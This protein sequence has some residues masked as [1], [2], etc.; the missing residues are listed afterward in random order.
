MSQYS[1]DVYMTC[2]KSNSSIPCYT[3]LDTLTTRLTDIGNVFILPIV[4]FYSF[5]LNLLCIIVFTRKKM[6]GEVNELFFLVSIADFIFAIVCI[7]LVLAR[8]GVY[9]SFGY[10]YILRIY[11]QFVFLY[12]GNVCLSF[13]I[14]IDNYLAFIK[15]SAFSG[16]IKK[17][18]F[19]IRKGKL[20]IFIVIFIASLVN[21]PIYVLSRRIKLIG[22]LIKEDESN[23]F[24]LEP[25]Y[26]VSNIVVKR[27]IFDYLL[28]ALTIIRG[29]F[30]LIFL[31]IL[32]LIVYIR[33][34]LY[35]RKKKKNQ[36]DNANCI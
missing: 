2:N 22:Y 1:L 26:S 27:S 7:F 10:S 24:Y 33:L 15:L 9:C 6:T 4:N 13:T 21:L 32:D 14:L 3:S 28:F 11:E 34:K 36:R 19:S 25:L 23:L 17:Q 8:C 18:S 5:I 12:I 20:K 29:L 35:M 30:L 16:K 31:S